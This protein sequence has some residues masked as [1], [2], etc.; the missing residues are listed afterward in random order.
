MGVIDCA[1]HVRDAGLARGAEHVYASRHALSPVVLGIDLALFFF[2]VVAAASE[3]VVGATAY[4]ASAVDLF[5]HLG[6][7]GARVFRG[8]IVGHHG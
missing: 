5:L 2:E 7:R 4:P 1:H 6:E 3:F 8:V